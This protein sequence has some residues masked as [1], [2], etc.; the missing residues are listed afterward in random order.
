MARNTGPSVRVPLLRLLA[1][2]FLTD[3]NA[4]VDRQGIEQEIVSLPVF[5][6]EQPSDAGPVGFL[7]AW[8]ITHGVGGEDGFGSFSGGG[9]GSCF[10][11]VFEPRLSRLVGLLGTV[12]RTSAPGCNPQGGEDGLGPVCRRPLAL[13][14]APGILPDELPLTGRV[15]DHECARD[16][17]A[18]TQYLRPY[19]SA[20]DGKVPTARGRGLSRRV[21]HG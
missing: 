4:T 21:G 20:P 13:L 1:G 16:S 17:L 8:G 15:S 7:A 2:I 19:A 18:S 10:H 5:V 3:D 6:R 12:H 14:A 9:H 11:W